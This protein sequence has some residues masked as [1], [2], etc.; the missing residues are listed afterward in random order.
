MANFEHLKLGDKVT[1]LL[2]GAP[3]PMIVTGIDT[4]NNII[5]CDAI[6]EDGSIFHGQWTFD[7]NSGV[8]E[9]AELQ[10]G[11]KFGRTGSYLVE[12]K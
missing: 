11:I 2:A 5:T 7:R 6:T 8:E 1:R 3:M 10:W 4:I 12:D 9:D